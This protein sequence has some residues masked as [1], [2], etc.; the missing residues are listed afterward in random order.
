MSRG[1]TL[2]VLWYMY[3]VCPVLMRLATC[4]YSV[5]IRWCPFDL[6]CEEWTSGQVTEFPR[7]VLHAHS[8]FVQRT[9]CPFRIRYIFVLSVIHPLHVREFLVRY[10]SGRYAL[11]TTSGTNFTTTETTFFIGWT[12]FAFFLSGW[13][14]LPLSVNMWQ[15]HFIWERSGSVVECL[16]RDR[17]V[18]G[19]SL[20]GVIALWSLSKTHSSKLSTG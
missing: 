6:N 4:R 2:L 7:R 5:R 1:W 9:F 3:T 14:P 13:C 10:L 17:R 20:T 18:A 19:S 15:H 16:T 12:F 8:V 11:F